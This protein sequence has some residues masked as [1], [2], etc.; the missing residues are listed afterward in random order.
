MWERRPLNAA[1]E[2]YESLVSLPGAGPPGGAAGGRGPGWPPSLRETA[3]RYALIPGVA[4]SGRLQQ[5]AAEGDKT[6]ALSALRDMLEALNRSWDGG[7]SIPTFCPVR[8]WPSGPVLLPGLLLELQRSPSFP[9][10]RAGISGPA[11]TLWRRDALA[12]PAPSYRKKSFRQA[13]GLEHFK[14]VLKSRL[15]GRERPRPVSWPA[16][17][18]PSDNPDG[19]LSH[20]LP[21]DPSDRGFI[22]S[23]WRRDAL[24]VPPPFFSPSCGTMAGNNPTRR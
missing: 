20:Y 14:K 16:A 18:S 13:A 15:I 19:F 5:A 1:T 4:S 23:L 17:N 22:D 8:R 12:S 11:E 21:P 10:G 6:A 7:G 24:S 3:E 9:P 2:V